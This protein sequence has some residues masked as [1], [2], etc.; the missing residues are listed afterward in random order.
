MS[1][2]QQ[3]PNF[4]GRLPLMARSSTPPSQQFT[5]RARVLFVMVA[6][7]ANEDC[8]LSHLSDAFQQLHMQKERTLAQSSQ[9]T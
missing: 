2:F 8:L 1:Y 6:R 5:M 7:V 4:A 9:R 3:Y